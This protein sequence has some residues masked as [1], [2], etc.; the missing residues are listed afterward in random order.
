MTN[1]DERHKKTEKAKKLVA[2]TIAQLIVD[3]AIDIEKLDKKAALIIWQAVTQNLH[4]EDNKP[5]QA[6]TA[7]EFQPQICIT[8]DGI[9]STTVVTEFYIGERDFFYIPFKVFQETIALAKSL[10]VSA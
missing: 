1:S 4:L 7:I 10:R 8:E 2:P 5:L 3:F 9:R 6:L